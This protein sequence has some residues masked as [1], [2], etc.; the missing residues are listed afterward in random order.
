MSSPTVREISMETKIISNKNLKYYNEYGGFSQDGK[1]YLIKTNLENKLPTV[2]SHILS[3]EKFGTLLTENMGG[4]TWYKNSKLNRITAWSND[5]I[6]DI[7]SEIIFIQDEETSTICS[8]GVNPISDNN[9]YYS[10]YG[11]GY[12][13]YNHTSNGI[14]QELEIFVPII[15]SVKINILHLK[16]TLPKRKKIKLYYCIKPVLGE[17]E[18]RTNRF[19]SSEFNKN[20]N[21]CYIKNNTNSDYNNIIYFSSSEKIKNVQNCNV[22]SKGIETL[23]KKE[24]D[25]NLEFGNFIKC[26]IEVELE[27]FSNKDISIVL[28]AEEKI[29]DCKNIAYKYSNINNCYQEYEKVKKYWQDILN[30]VQVQ[31]PIES[32]NIM[33][34]G[35]SMYQTLVSRILGR[36]GFYQS[37][38]AYGFRDQLQDTICLKYSDA[39]LVKKQIIKH[40]E[41][42]FEQGDV[43]HWWHDETQKGIRTRFSDDL[44]WLPYLV[45]EYINFTGDYSILDIETNY[46]NGK[47]LPDG[48]DENYDRYEKSELKENIFKHCIRAIERALNNTEKKC[49]NFGENG[50]PKIGSGDWNDGFSTVGNKGQGES[51]WLGFFLYDVLEKFSLICENRGDSLNSE[52][53]RLIAEKLKKSLNTNGWDGR[54]YRRAYMDNGEV[55]GSIE[56]EECR[57]DSIAQT[58]ATISKAGDNDKKYISMESLENHLVDKENGIIKL[59]DP[60]FENGK[61]EPGYIK[62]YLPGTRENGGQYTHA[63]IW[64]IIAEAILGYGNKACELYRMINPIEHSRTRAEAEKYKVEPYVIPADV[65]GQSNL[66]G[67]GGWTWYTGSSS[68]FYEA[69]I[70]YILGIQ[71][72]KG[73]LKMNPCISNEWKEYEV[74]LKYGESIYNIKVKN[75]N[76]KNTGIEK[77]LYNGDIIEEKQIKISENGG[78]N[79]IEIIM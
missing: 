56:N 8:I 38:G 63:A 54:W 67:R 25:I 73:V 37:G 60:P 61:L 77:F 41:H 75:P 43:E 16:N 9:D 28:G 30:K 27:A 22:T 40:S 19:I 52:K 23:Q 4:Y 51:I 78:I 69:G 70:K 35:W 42:Q 31:T 44:L 20:C 59:L 72:E 53:Y 3:N 49:G 14:E 15:D 64:V 5:Q 18:I 76:G 21:C 13:K 10:T 55:L 74:K 32:I 34:N 2:W 7:P 79:E 68:W 46:L 26:E 36:T 57:I 24:D 33:L 6:M 39:E 48:I 29:I 11:F 47:L 50:L 17:D 1:E 65:Y 62:S 12:A 66:A 45:A 58:W 71:I